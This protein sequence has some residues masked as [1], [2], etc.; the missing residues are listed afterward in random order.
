M[1]LS[2]SVGIA[3]LLAMPSLGEVVVVEGGEWWME[4]LKPDPATMAARSR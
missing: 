1:R 3:F 2:R 4:P